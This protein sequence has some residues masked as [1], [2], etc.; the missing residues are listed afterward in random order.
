[1]SAETPLSKGGGQRVLIVVKFCGVGVPR[2][3][4][5]PTIV[6]R[7]ERDAR[8]DQAPCQEA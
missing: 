4:A 2:E 8:F 7:D 6:D 3:G 1:M 5:C